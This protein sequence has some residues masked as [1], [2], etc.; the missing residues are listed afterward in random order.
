[1]EAFRPSN[2]TI[3]IIWCTTIRSRSIRHHPAP[4]LMMAAL[5]GHRTCLCNFIRC[6]RILDTNH[7]A[8]SI[9]TMA[10]RR[11]QILAFQVLGQGQGQDQ[12]QDQD[13][14]Q[15]RVQEQ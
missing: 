13:R 8:T 10:T 12:D 1:M 3:S 4:T 9:T 2:E 7:Q 15:D 6:R 14:A 5:V 11:I